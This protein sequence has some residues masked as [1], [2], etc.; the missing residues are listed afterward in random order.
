MDGA[1]NISGLFDL[2]LEISARESDLMRQ[3]RAALIRDDTP[4]ALRLAR[5][6]VGLDDQT[7]ADERRALARAEKKKR[8]EGR[9]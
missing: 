5:E 7:L 1:E 4:E 6:L 2:A 8:A 3:M 9:R